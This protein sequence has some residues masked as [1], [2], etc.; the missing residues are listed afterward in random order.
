MEKDNIG[1]NAGVVWQKVDAKGAMSVSELKKLTKL[2][3]RQI[4][5]ALGWLAREN[6]I[7][8]YYTRDELFVSLI[9]H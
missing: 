4:Y 6:K 9:Y 3:M 5:L 8:F 2:D 1:Q 7:Y